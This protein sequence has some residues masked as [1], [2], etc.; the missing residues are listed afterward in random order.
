MPRSSLK[1][2]LKDYAQAHRILLGID[3]DNPEMLLGTAQAVKSHDVPLFVQMT[4]ET[5]AIW[6]YEAM[7]A[8]MAAVLD[9]LPTPIAWHLDHDSHMGDIARVLDYGFTSVMYDGSSLPIDQNIRN[10]QEVVKRAHATRTVVEAEIGHVHKP[11]EP[12]A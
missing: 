4:P 6:E 11:G 12:L 10:T 8:M 1:N 3:A 5:L 9:Q 2:E 7:T